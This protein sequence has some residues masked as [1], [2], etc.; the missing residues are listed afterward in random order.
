MMAP[1]QE[2]AAKAGEEVTFSQLILGF[3]SAALYYTGDSPLAGKKEGEKNLHLA[4]YN[5][6]I[7]RL[8]AEKTSGNL[9]EEETKL[10]REVLSDLDQRFAAAFQS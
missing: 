5:I 7:V 3:A 10:T 6:D 4:R 1:G 8:L 2:G 9:S